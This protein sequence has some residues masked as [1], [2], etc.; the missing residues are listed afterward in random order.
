MRLASPALLLLL[1]PAC[2][3]LGDRAVKGCPPGDTCSSET[4]EGLAF[5]GPYF[6]DAGF[7]AD[8]GV[9]VT[10]VGGTQTIDLIDVATGEPLAS[11]FLATTTDPA[12][13]VDATGTSD[14]TVAGAAAGSARLEIRSYSGLLH[15]RL[16]ISASEVVSVELVPSWNQ[17]RDASTT[18]EAFAGA[19]ASLV[20]ALTDVEGRRLVDEGMT[21][22]GGTRGGWDGVSLT[23]PEGGAELRV[24]AGSA[25]EPVALPIAA[26]AQIDDFVVSQLLE[27][28]PRVGDI[29][30]WCFRAR[31][32]GADVLF[33]PWTF[34][35]EGP[36]H[37]DGI[38]FFDNC[39]NVSLDAVGLVTITAQAP[40]HA[41]FTATFDVFEAEGRAA[42]RMP[43]APEAPP[44]LGERASAISAGE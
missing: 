22:D 43:V 35:V 21:I 18:W 11:R 2:A 37:E 34:T 36:A 38:S 41:P 32:Q 29:Q 39:V 19:D 44:Q 26:T 27:G 15:D 30:G 25:T 42:R 7:F 3:D 31:H 33:V 5:S 1:A 17:F 24:T 23:V 16:L 6:G 8:P 4:P 10:A 13:A 40:D 12:I 28:Q 20:V 9:K 14:V